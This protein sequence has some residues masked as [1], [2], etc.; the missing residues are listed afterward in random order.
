V[1]VV[2]RGAGKKKLLVRTRSGYFDKREV[3]K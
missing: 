3:S 2:A 1:R